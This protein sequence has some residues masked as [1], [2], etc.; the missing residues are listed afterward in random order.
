MRL[1]WQ[2]RVSMFTAI[3]Y[4]PSTRA[5]SIAAL[6][7]VR[8][9]SAVVRL[10]ISIIIDAIQCSVMRSFAH[11]GVEIFKRH[12]PFADRDAARSIVL[13]GGHVRIEASGFHRTP[14]GVNGRPPSAVRFSVAPPFSTAARFRVSAR[15]ITHQSGTCFPA[16]A[17]TSPISLTSHGIGRFD[18][19]KQAKA[20]IGEVTRSV[21][22]RTKYPLV[23]AVKEG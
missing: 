21:H 14:D 1:R 6:F 10:I 12:P 19:R 9:P 2:R 3:Q 23:N 7:F 22:R 15:Q 16:V 11:V 8:P 5:P 4:F 13:V 18:C 20:L 17:E